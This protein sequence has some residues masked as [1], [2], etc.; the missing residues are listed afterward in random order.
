MACELDRMILLSEFL[1][2]WR[3]IF[4]PF[5]SESWRLTGLFLEVTFYCEDRSLNHISDA[6]SDF[7]PPTLVRLTSDYVPCFTLYFVVQFSRTSARSRRRKVRSFWKHPRDVSITCE[8]LSVQLLI[9][10]LRHR[11]PFV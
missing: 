9:D 6:C 4:V 7:L 1:E 3:P 2:H 5:K 8:N 10:R 11:I